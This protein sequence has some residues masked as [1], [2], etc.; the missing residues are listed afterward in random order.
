MNLAVLSIIFLILA[1]FIGFKF[2]VNTG[3]VAIGLALIIG[4][5]GGMSSGKIIGG[6]SSSLFITMLGVSYLFAIAADNKTLE[7]VAKKLVAMAGDKTFLIPIIIF[8]ISVFL[9]GIGPGTVPVMGIMSVFSMSLAAQ[10]KLNPILLTS[11]ALLG[12]Q[13]GGLTPIAPTGILAQELANQ[14]G[15]GDLGSSVMLNQFIASTI[16][17]GV[18]YIVLKGWKFKSE[19]KL[20]KD[21]LPKFNRDQIITIVGIVLMVASVLLLNFNVGLASFLI[22]SVLLM[23]NVSTTKAAMNN[24]AWST[25]ILVCGVNVLM[26]I[27]IELGGINLI[28]KGLASVMG[29][30]TAFPIIGVSSGIMSWF[31]STSGV[32]MPTMIPTVPGIIDTIGNVSITAMVSAIIITAHTAGCSPISSGGAQSLAAYCTLTGAND[33][34]EKKMF[35]ELFAVAIGGVVFMAFYGMLGGFSIF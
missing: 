13:G 14:A 24:I 1:I 34:E 6:F 9:A 8:F 12:A 35:A 3:F 10:M 28:S 22:G 16:Y 30:N 20:N 27:V 15:I 29:Q 25:L 21:D 7:L 23:L 4:T 11:A 2:G 18:V 31:S 26:N 5:L 32:V 19:T 17:F 33:A